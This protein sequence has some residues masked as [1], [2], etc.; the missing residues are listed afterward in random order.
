MFSNAPTSRSLRGISFT[1]EKP[2][3]RNA[4]VLGCSALALVG[5]GGGG[6][7]STPTPPPPTLAA[8]ANFALQ[9]LA[10]F[11]WSATPGATAPTGG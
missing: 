5:C 1:V 2:L 3:L 11:S 6:S 9:G 4:L 10:D 7:E 8:P